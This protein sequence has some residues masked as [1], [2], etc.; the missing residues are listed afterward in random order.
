MPSPTTAL[1]LIEDA[2]GLTNAVGQDQ[3]LTNDEVSDCLRVFNDVL[4]DWST[5]RLAV[6]GQANQTFNTVANQ[7]TY[8]IG[9]GGNWNTVRPERI[10]EPA[11][12]TVQSVTFPFINVTQAEYNLI[13]YK[14][15][16][17]GGTDYG[18]CY[19]YVNE[20]PLGLIT[21]WP[22]PNA[23]YPITF[24]I[25]RILSQV[26]NAATSISFPQGYAKAF[27]YTMGVELAPLFG[28]NVARDYPEVM[29]I[30]A[31]TLGNIK[32][33]NKQPQV[34]EYDIALRSDRYY[35]WRSWP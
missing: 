12:A 6:F 28:K 23:V 31:Q 21:L 5:Q 8:T 11:Y 3:T 19:L 35:N 7:A 18:Q 2:L 17:G 29:R 4:E 32:R 1:T 33:A 34:M 10:S 27:K 30:Q 20:Y 16:P 25:D 14:A 15:Q 24:S 9:S 22:V 26:T 13:A